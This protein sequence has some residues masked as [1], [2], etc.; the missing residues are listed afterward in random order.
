MIYLI[1]LHISHEKQAGICMIA[2]RLKILK[3]IP[4][5]ITILH[6]LKVIYLKP[7]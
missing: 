7:L 5:N 1:R 4:L 3:N 6:I 2:D